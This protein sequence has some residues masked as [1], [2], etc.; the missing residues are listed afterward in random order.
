MSQS[1]LHQHEEKPD[2]I[3]QVL[4]VACAV[5]CVSTPI[6]VTLAPAASSFLGGFHPVLLL[7]VI[8]V[9]AWAFVPGYRCH[10]S[11]LVLSLAGGGIA[12]LTLA[13]FVFAD[14]HAFDAGLSLIGATMMMFAHWHNR[15]LLKHGVNG[16]N[17]PV[18]QK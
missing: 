8:A 15:K 7:G 12:C 6:I 11:R 1:Q 5:H 10:H 2:V 16:P 14:N 9:A 17:I 3:G 13:A 18:A 4:S